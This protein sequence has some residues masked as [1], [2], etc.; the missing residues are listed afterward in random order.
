M[1]F[2]GMLR[3]LDNGSGKFLMY[4]RFIQIVLDKQLDGL[5]THKEKYDVSFYTKKV[6]ANMKRIGKVF[7]GKETPVFPTMIQKPRQPKRKTT[8]VPQPNESTAIAT[9]EAVRKE[10]V[11]VWSLNEDILKINDFDYQYAVSI[12]E[13]TA[14]NGEA[15]REC[16]LSG[17]Y[18][19]TTVLVHVIEATDDSPAVPE[20]TKVET[21]TNMSPENKAHFLAEK[22]AIQLILTGIGDDIY[23]TVDA[24][25]T[26]QEM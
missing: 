12:K 25:Q 5:P 11:T 10:G 6:F 4:P 24:C 14:P 13:D 2:D 23:L 26:A 8:K 18:K 19:P 15:L 1:I 17:P 16:I 7:F 3:N 20:H 21:P 22:E 9:D